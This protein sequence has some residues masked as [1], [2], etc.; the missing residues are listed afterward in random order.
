MLQDE[1]D[2]LLAYADEL[3]GAAEEETQ[4]SEEDVVTHLICVN[5]RQSLANYLAGFLMQRNIA[6]NQ[7]ITLQGLLDQCK[8]IDARFE[9]I[10]L[11]PMHCRCET[12]DNDYCLDLE[13]VDQCMHIA[14]W[15]RSVVRENAPGY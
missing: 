12:H 14:R 11:T 6:I 2:K 10:D 15:A 3:L 9:E 1:V 8:T 4:R 13:Q 7:P 5:S